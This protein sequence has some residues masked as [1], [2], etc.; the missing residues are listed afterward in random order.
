MND[1]QTTGDIKTLLQRMSALTTSMDDVV[2]QLESATQDQVRR[3]ECRNADAITR[4]FERLD[5]IADHVS[6][7]QFGDV[8]SFD[9]RGDVYMQPQAMGLV[10]W[11]YAMTGSKTVRVRIGTQL[12]S[13]EPNA[14]V[15]V[16]G[17][18]G[19]DQLHVWTAF[20]SP[21]A[22]EIVRGCEE[23]SVHLLRRLQ[24]AGAR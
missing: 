3:S 24:I 21:E 20:D 10:E 23:P 2:E 14:R 17:R 6:R 18:V 5:R 1:T 11:F 4:Q 19:D 22:V 13:E 9:H 7:M 15:S 16:D 8:Y 12:L